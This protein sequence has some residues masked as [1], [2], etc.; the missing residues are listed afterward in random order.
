MKI[1]KTTLNYIIDIL[2]G[3]GFL[4]SCIT[5]IILLFNESGGYQGGRNPLYY[6]HEMWVN[7]HIWSSLVMSAGVAAH[8]ILHWNWMVCMTK[9]LL[10]PG[11][12]KDA[13]RPDFI[14]VCEMN[15]DSNYD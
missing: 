12:T 2:T 13:N 4:V 8:L 6:I 14:P 1:K 11:K 7:I 10:S 5:G 9:K 3:L 15:T